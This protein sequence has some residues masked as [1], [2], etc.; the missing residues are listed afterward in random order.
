MSQTNVLWIFCDQLIYHNLSCNGDPNI[1]TP[2]LDRLAS[3]GAN[4]RHAYTPCPVCTPA[5][6]NVLT[7]QYG[8]ID[9]GAL[10]AGIILSI[11]P[12]ILL[13]LLLQ[14]YYMQGLMGGAVK[15]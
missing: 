3:E 14:R 4:F 15:G 9:W 8:N 2:N 11:S 6:A 12:C 7:G 5:R 10:Q 13:F 1:Q